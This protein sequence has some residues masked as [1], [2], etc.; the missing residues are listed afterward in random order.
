MIAKVLDAEMD[1]HGPMAD[2]RFEALFA[3]APLLP[4]DA[5]R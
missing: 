5:L 4:P 1:E 3:P 2:S